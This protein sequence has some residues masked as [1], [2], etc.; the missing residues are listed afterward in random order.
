MK[1]LYILELIRVTF[2]TPG[3]FINTSA[4]I[5][6]QPFEGIYEDY[7]GIKQDSVA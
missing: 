7:I 3:T 1:D 2:K 6:E 4:L 5:A